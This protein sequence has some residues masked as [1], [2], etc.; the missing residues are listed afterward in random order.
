VRAVPSLFVVGAVQESV[1]VPLSAGGELG[2]ED[3]VE[4]LVEEEPVDAEPAEELAL[5]ELGSEELVAAVLEAEA[6][7]AG[8]E[9]DP[10]P[11][12]V[13]TVTTT[14]RPKKTLRNRMDISSA[15]DPEP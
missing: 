5:E 4:G 9:A 14:A 1:A 6:E 13:S 10:P 3:P 8:V 2:G 12:P 15:R 7:V 11:Q